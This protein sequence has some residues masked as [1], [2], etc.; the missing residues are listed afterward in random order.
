MGFRSFIESFVV[1]VFHEDVGM[2]SNLP[3]L[4]NPQVTF[5][6]FSLC[7]AQCL[8]YLFCTMFPSP[9]ILQ[10]HIKFDTCAITTLEELLGQG[11]FGGSIDHLVHC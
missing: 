6:M 11:S 2:V 1:K 3:M 9:G 4:I 10:H 7:Y 5:V 8:G